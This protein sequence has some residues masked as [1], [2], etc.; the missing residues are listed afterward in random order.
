MH[1]RIESVNSASFLG[2]TKQIGFKKKK[3]A[4][5]PAHINVNMIKNTRKTGL[6]LGFNH[7][8]FAC[9]ARMLKPE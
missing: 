8:P 1:Q 3:I 4:E 9:E 5:I 2:Q 7:E 6:Y